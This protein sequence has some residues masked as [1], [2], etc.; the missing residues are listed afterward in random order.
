M[1][2]APKLLFISAGIFTLLFCL[3]VL[4]LGMI[5]PSKYPV[6]KI[7]ES[8][9]M[10]LDKG[11]IRFHSKGAGSDGILF[12]HGFN[13]SLNNWDK[14]WSELD[15]C[16]RS[17]RLDIPGFGESEWSTDSFTLQ[18]QGK[19]IIEFLNNLG[20][21]KVTVV[22]TSMGG[23]VAAWI[24][25][26]YPER[27]NAALLLAPSGLTDS[28]KYQGLLGYLYKPGLLNRISVAIAGHKIFKALFP[29]SRILQSLTVTSSYGPLWEDTIKKIAKPVVI[30][31]SR[32][33]DRVPF[34]Y[35]K[36][37]ANKIDNSL[38]IPLVENVGHNI[39]GRKPKLV[40]SI[41]CLMSLGIDNTSILKTIE[42]H[43]KEEDA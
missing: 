20:I 18:E 31:W 3:Y 39:P 8:E 26:N 27:T 24:A 19:R 17:I 32:G 42:Q 13:G 6:N 10:Q 25:S 40:A 38:L 28:L 12:L 9:F 2:I 15:T 5:G 14:V 21:D 22:G 23:S 4:A 33:D 34:I 29:D 36:A 1:Q 37:V 41:A 16:T 30:L 35:A 7:E 43:L 11:R